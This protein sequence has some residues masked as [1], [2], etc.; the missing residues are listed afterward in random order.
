M[1]T[2]TRKIIGWSLLMIYVGY[3]LFDLFRDAINDFGFFQGVAVGIGVLVLW[4]VVWG[5]FIYLIR[6]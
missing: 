4:T 6:D 3:V 2:K 1:K 5:V